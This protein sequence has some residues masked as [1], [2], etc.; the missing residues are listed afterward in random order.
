MGHTVSYGKTFS[1]TQ[2]DHIIFPQLG[3]F[4]V[5]LLLCKKEQDNFFSSKVTHSCFGLDLESVACEHLKKY[6][7]IE[8][9]VY[10]ANI[11]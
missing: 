8:R 6:I 9:G 3:F 11:N 7:S 1:P 4:D 10:I 5:T 2:S